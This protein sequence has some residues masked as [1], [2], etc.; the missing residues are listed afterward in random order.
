MPG[1]SS[2]LTWSAHF[3]TS[4]REMPSTETSCVV[5]RASAKDKA[6]KQLGSLV[7]VVRMCGSV[8][9][10]AGFFAVASAIARAAADGTRDIGLQRAVGA[11]R[12]QV[13]SAFL[14][15]GGMIGLAG[16]LVAVSAGNITAFFLGRWALAEITAPGAESF[17]GRGLEDLQF[18]CLPDTLY[19]FSPLV[20]L[21][22]LATGIAVCILAG[23]PAALRASRL[24][25]ISALRADA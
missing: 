24:D 17:L 12:L 18:S 19:H 8:I 13:S 4:A 2:S 16:A 14:A 3:P 23:F 22:L 20:S 15:Q 9:V 6:E 11:T 7:L 21:A 25:P 1:S 10:L 5:S